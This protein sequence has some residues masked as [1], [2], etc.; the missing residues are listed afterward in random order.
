M[1]AAVIH[2]YGSPD[3]LK[4]EDMPDPSPG[5]GEVLIRTAATSI[6]PLDVKMR[7]GAVKE[8]FPVS[9]PAILGW[10]VSGTVE[11]VGPGVKNFTKGDKVFGQTAQAD[12]TMCVVKGA[13][14]ARVPDG[15][16]LVSVAALPTVTTTGAELA[17][18][19]LEGKKGGTLLVTG[20]A[21]NVGRSAVFAAKEKGATVIAG[22]RKAQIE[23]ARGL[24]ADRILA[25]D[26][27]TALAGLELLDA[28]ADTVNGPTA[29]KLIGKLKQGGVFASVLSAPTNAAEYPSIAVKTM[30]V[31]ADPKVLLHMAEAV[32]SGKLAIPLGQRFALK[33]ANKA[34]AAAEKSAAGKILLVA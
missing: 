22:V 21:G 3:E 4:F 1:K 16:D 17:A 15:M 23:E 28:I 7:S 11:E 20:A 13:D 26:D 31:K 18:L 9:F 25:L 2:E 6:N 8:Y 10:D 5:P 24:G 19:A 29:T 12:A 30:Q 33:D 32:R 14:L 27:E 34:H